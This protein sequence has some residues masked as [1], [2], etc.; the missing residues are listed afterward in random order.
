MTKIDSVTLHLKLLTVKGDTAAP[1]QLKFSEISEHLYDTAKYYS[2]KP[3]TLTGKD[4]TVDLPKLRADTI[5]D[6]VITIPTNSPN[7]PSDFGVYLTRTQSMLFDTSSVIAPDFRSFFKGLYFQILSPGNP[8]LTTL[9]IARPG[10]NA[11]Y[12]NYFTVYVQDD[13]GN[14]TG[15]DF[16]IDAKSRQ[17]G[18]NLFEHD[19]AKGEAGKKISHLNDSYPDSLSYA[20]IMNGV[21][22][23][24]EIPGFE[25]MKNSA[26]FK[27]VAIN[28]ARLIIPYVI[29]KSTFTNTK[30]P[31]TLYMRFIDFKGRKTLVRDYLGAGA[32]FYGGTPDTVNKIYNINIATYLQDYLKDKT[33]SITPQLEIFLY[34]TDPYNVVFRTNNNTKESTKFELTYSKF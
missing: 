33:D 28:R 30:I 6:I 13:H 2:N 29:D 18:L 23:R 14:S 3:I 26:D 27:N 25:A 19:F 4:W 31:S 1:H 9:S 17:A 8:I 12:V 22:T 32:V 34:P 21:F 5:N 11:T 10:S 20:Q 15:Y 24:L 7:D 16:I